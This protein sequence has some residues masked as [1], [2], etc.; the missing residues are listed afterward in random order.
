MSIHFI[1][2]PQYELPIT[3]FPLSIAQSPHLSCHMSNLAMCL[4]L[5]VSTVFAQSSSLL[6]STSNS[7]STPSPFS[8]HTLPTFFPICLGCIAVDPD[9]LDT[10][11]LAVDSL[12]TCTMLLVGFRTP[13]YL[14]NVRYLSL[15]S[16]LHFGTLMPLGTQRR[17][18]GSKAVSFSSSLAPHT[19]VCPTS[20]SVHSVSHAKNSIFTPI[21][22]LLRSLQQQTSYGLDCVSHWIVCFAH[23]PRNQP[24]PS[25]LTRTSQHPHMFF[26]PPH[27]RNLAKIIVKLP[28]PAQAPVKVHP[29]S[30]LSVDVLLYLL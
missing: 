11:H 13:F 2:I 24:P 26:T 14:C 7:T 6:L 16:N 18:P 1:P 9:S 10:L 8:A 17:L 5:H 21:S 19:C 3:I 27:S 22:F 12:Q 28:P 29:S 25:K 23:H 20:I 15:F 4:A 30:L